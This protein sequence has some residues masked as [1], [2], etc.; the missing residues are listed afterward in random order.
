MELDFT[1]LLDL[2]GVE[3]DSW[4]YSPDAIT[5]NL[6][7]L[8]KGIYCSYFHDYTEELHQVRPILVR[9]LSAFGKPVYLKLPRRQFYCRICQRYITEQLNFIDYRRKYTQRYEVNIYSQVHSSSIEQISKQENLN[10]EQVKNIVNYVEQKQQAK[11]DVDKFKLL[12]VNSC[13]KN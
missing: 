1:N 10:I 5:F 6:K 4:H 11:L 2:P 12:S 13:H 8:A 3:V 9:D 7:I